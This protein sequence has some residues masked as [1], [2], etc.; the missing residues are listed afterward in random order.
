MFEGN[1][2]LFVLDYKQASSLSFTRA[3]SHGAFG[4]KEMG[5]DE[6]MLESLVGRLQKFCSSV[7]SC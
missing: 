2:L 6:G 7:R 5:G 1:R 3:P 4:K